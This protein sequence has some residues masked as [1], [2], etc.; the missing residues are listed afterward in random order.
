MHAHTYRKKQRQTGS[1]DGAQAGMMVGAQLAVSSLMI[2]G[3]KEILPI[4]P[5]K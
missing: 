2:K 3:A 4:L 5:A 1:A